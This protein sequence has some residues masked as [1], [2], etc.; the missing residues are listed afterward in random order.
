MDWG[1]LCSVVLLHR[2]EIRLKT[3]IKAFAMKWILLAVVVSALL[4]F[5][6]SGFADV[7]CQDGTWDAFRQTCVPD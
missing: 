2:M 3:Y 5:L 7:P 4:L 1:I 6:W